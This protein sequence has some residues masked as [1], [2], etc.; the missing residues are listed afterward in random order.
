MAAPTRTTAALATA[1][2]PATVG[3]VAVGFDILGFATGATGDRVTVRR[4]DK[5]TVEVEAIE[6]VVTDLPTDP[7]SNT[8]TA[9][10]LR[11]RDKLGVDT[12]F[13]VT[14]EKGIPLGSGMGGSASSAA[15][16]IVAAAALLDRPLTPRQLLRFALHGE[17]VASGATHADNVA[18]ALFGGLVLVPCLDPLEIVELP[19]PTGIACVIVHP[20][21]QINTRMAR[22]VLPDHFSL[23]EMVAQSGKLAGF[24]AACF[25][26]DLDLLANSMED[27][28]IEPHRARLIPG[29]SQVKRAALDSGALGASIS[30]AGPTVFAW[31]S[32]DRSDAVEKAMVEAF[33]DHGIA[34]RAWTGPIDGRGAYLE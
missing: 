3:N 33:A 20:D 25:R 11:L 7:A 9:G 6:G 15:A 28:I 17:A 29:F 13:S 18:P 21:E 23:P 30:G 14:I 31:C 32:R 2:A 1:F 5:P 27:L 22:Q 24:V 19:I 8:A 12:G 16:S 26:D 34:A 4:I 10:L